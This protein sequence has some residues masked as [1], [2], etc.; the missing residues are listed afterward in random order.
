[1]KFKAYAKI[2][3]G[4]K[5]IRKRVD[6]Y[7]DLEMVMAP[8]NLFDVLEF[9]KNKT[10]K[11]NVV[12]NIYADNIVLKAAKIM[13]DR[14]DIAEGLNI[15]IKKNIPDQAGLGGG[16]A[17][18]AV[19]LKA[20]NKIFKLH[21]DMTALLAIAEELGSD[22]AFCLYN[23]KA[24]VSGKGEKVEIINSKLKAYIVLV[25]PE[26]KCSTKVI[27]ENHK[28]INASNVTALLDAV[29]KGSLNEVSKYLFNDLERT[30]NLLND[31][32]IKDIKG[33]LINHGALNAS[34]SGSGSLVFGLYKLKKDAK[35][36]CK[37]IEK[38][39]KNYRVCFSTLRI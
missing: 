30:V 20:I 26:F 17:D 25:Q 5:V 2:N 11:M 14:F 23:K 1:M 22:V 27:F 10:G 21:L 7:H 38:N 28:I 39:N 32:K 13:Q 24:L 36:V 3:L 16:S 4:L 9:K 34:M 15:S 8:I 35:K 6:N 29:K 33:L 37:D 12:N 31:N 19:T 18:A